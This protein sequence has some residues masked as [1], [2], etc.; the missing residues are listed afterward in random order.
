[1]ATSDEV[2]IGKGDWLFL[3]QG[4]NNVSSQYVRS[5]AAQF[6]LIHWRLIISAR[7]RRLR[8]LGIPY[9]HVLMPEKITIYDHLLDGLAIDWRLSPAFRL[10]YEDEYYKLF[11][12]RRLNIPKY[13]SRNRRWRSTLIDL[14][15]P[16][17]RQRDLQN[18]FYRTDSHLSFAGRML[19][20]REI[21][22]AVGAEPVRDFE[23]RPALYHPGWAGDLGMGFVPPRYEGTMLHDLQ[24]DAVR[25][26]ANPIVAHRERRASEGTLHTGAHVIYRNERARDPRCVMLFGDSYANFAPI[27]LTIMLAET[28]RELHFIWSTQLDFGYIERIRPDL[29]LTEMSER[30][31]FRPSTDDWDFEG[32]VRQRYGA[33]LAAGSDD[34]PDP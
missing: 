23:E 19:A 22:R 6:F 1:M 14:I 30:F 7:E 25:V 34:G 8:D 15:T 16:M 2:H 31:V 33:E 18:L 5:P 20:Y 26:Y 10:I 13:I 4:T 27:G 24:R 29:V 32:Y 11:P 9:K 3:L 21:C 28:F 17:R 12:F